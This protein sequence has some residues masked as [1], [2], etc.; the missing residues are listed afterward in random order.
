[1]HLMASAR[2]DASAS[3]RHARKTG[4]SF[5]KNSKEMLVFES[6]HLGSELLS[7][8]RRACK[9]AIAVLPRNK[10]HLM[11]HVSP[12]RRRLRVAVAA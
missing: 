7:V 10:Y 6:K 1:M 5:R 11:W 12:G 9:I 2:I 8:T 4:L 3:S